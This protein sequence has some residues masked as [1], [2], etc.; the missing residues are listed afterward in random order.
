VAFVIGGTSWLSRQVLAH[1][2]ALQACPASP[3]SAERADAW[4]AW[5]P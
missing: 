1:D 5:S 3:L 4:L 2:P